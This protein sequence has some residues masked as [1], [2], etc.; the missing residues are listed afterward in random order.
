[1]E[2]FGRPVVIVL[3]RAEAEALGRQLGAA[4]YRGWTRNRTPAPQ[5]LLDLA[6]TLSRAGCPAG[7][8]PSRNTRKF[9]DGPPVKSSGQPEIKLST[10]V[11]SRVCVRGVR[12]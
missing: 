7:Q 2:V 10:S 11:H 9:R 1:M 3:S 12:R 4:V 5:L 6:G 8:D